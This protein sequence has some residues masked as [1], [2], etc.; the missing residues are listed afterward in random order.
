MDIVRLELI[1]ELTIVLCGPP[2][3]QYYLWKRGK[4]TPQQLRKTATL[5]APFYVLIF[6][7]LIAWMLE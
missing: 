1:A 7:V 3:Y 4:T 6:G 2:L 5:F